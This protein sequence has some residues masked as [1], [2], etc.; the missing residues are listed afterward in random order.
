MENKI[1]ELENRIKKL[2]ASVITLCE[3]SNSY[4]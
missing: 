4:A 2:E 1:I 3:S